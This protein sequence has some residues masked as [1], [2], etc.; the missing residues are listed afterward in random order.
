MSEKQFKIH[1]ESCRKFP[2]LPPTV[3]WEFIEPARDQAFWNH[4]QTLEELNRRGGMAPG[5]IL[6][7]LDRASLYPYPNEMDSVKILLKRLVEWH[8]LQTAKKSKMA[9]SKDHLDHI[10]YIPHK[11]T[12][13]CYNCGEEYQVTPC[14]FGMAAAVLKHFN[15]EHK[16][17][18]PSKEGS[19]L[20]ALNAAA[21]EALPEDKRNIVAYMTYPKPKNLGE[22]MMQALMMEELAKAEIH[23]D[24]NPKA[25]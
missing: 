19:E 13:A 9:K 25:S 3:P 24:I 23:P 4:G 12:A 7:A 16:K 2:E 8:S 15:K 14:S 11:G 17:C 18:K 10:R 6:C 1:S 20:L 5:E 21:F 22:K